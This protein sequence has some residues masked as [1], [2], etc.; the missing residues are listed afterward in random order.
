MPA[1]P[2]A[3]SALR[4]PKSII[5]G[6]IPLHSPSSEIVCTPFA[7]DTRFEYP[8]PD[9][10]QN[11]GSGSSSATSD[12]FNPAPSTSPSSNSF[13]ILSTSPQLSFLSYNA[14]HPKMKIQANPPIPPNLIKRHLRRTLNL[15]VRRRSS[16]SN[17]QSTTSD[18]S[19]MANNVD[20]PEQQALTPP[21]SS[22]FQE[23]GKT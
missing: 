11:C 23:R 10:S 8:F 15:L 6:D 22:T 2:S 13:P 14:T 9:I 19:A 16:G 5:L 3:E 18:G 20:E 4:R 21:G 17:Q 12:F 1:S 7:I